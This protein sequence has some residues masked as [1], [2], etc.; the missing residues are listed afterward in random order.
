MPNSYNGE[1]SLARH[2][3]IPPFL[4]E[5]VGSVLTLFDGVVFD[6]IH[7]YCG[8]C[9]DQ[10]RRHDIKR[11]RFATLLEHGQPRPVLVGVARYRCRG[12]GSLWYADEPFYHK[13]RHGVPVVDL[14]ITLSQKYP[15]HRTAQ[16]LE[17][18]GVLLD[19]GTVRAYARAK[20][21]FPQPGFTEMYGFP[22]PYRIIALSEF[23]AQ[24]RPV[25]GAELLAALGLPAAERTS[26][27]SFSPGKQK[28]DEEEQEEERISKDK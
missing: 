5:M 21:R 28:G 19:R 7:V 18:M 17:G 25:V 11:K 22:V 6:D 8:Q 26:L 15:Y 13:T 1:N 24:D 27:S 12:C 2:R 14:V 23:I 3:M 20:E 16:I 10:V 9:G 4:S